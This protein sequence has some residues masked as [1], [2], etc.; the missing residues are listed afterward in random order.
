MLEG[1]GLRLGF[2]RLHIQ[3]EWGVS[4]RRQGV[5]EVSDES[6]FGLVRQGRAHVCVRHTRSP[7]CTLRN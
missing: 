5:H 3:C 2:I 7:L 6:P 1:S 4:L